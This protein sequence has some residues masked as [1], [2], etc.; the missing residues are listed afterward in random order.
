MESIQQKVEY[1]KR[2]VINATRIYER[3]VKEDV[4]EKWHKILLL[5]ISQLNELKKKL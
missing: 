5:R 1:M 3:C 4:K 2:S